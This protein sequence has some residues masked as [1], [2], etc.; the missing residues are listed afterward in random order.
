VNC[1]EKVK[2]KAEEE[3]KQVNS[4]YAVLQNPSNNR[5]SQQP[6][7]AVSPA[8]IRFTGIGRGQKKTAAIRIESVGGP[9]TKFWMDDSPAP[10]L[11]VAEVN[12]LP[13]TP[14]PK[15]DLEA[16]GGA[17]DECSLPIRIED[18]KTGAQMRF[19]KETACWKPLPVLSGGRAF[20]ASG[21]PPSP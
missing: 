5:F 14:F 8:Y 17:P 13:P 10:W 1:P 6:K 21:C 20:T 19:R 16:T 4:A 9:Y 3:L 15:S 12:R 2:L 11:R 18:E 7:L